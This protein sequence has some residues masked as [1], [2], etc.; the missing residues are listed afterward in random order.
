MTVV[1]E[2]EAKARALVREAQTGGDPSL[3]R[4]K[5]K[6][7]RQEHEMKVEELLTDMQ[8]QLWKELIGEPLDMTD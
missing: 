2:L 7:L 3:I 8:R 1:Q 4:P 5:L 6:K